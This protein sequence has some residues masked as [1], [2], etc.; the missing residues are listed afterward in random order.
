M[1]ILQIIIIFLIVLMPFIKLNAQSEEIM[2]KWVGK[3][4]HDMILPEMVI[5]F[6]QH[7]K[8]KY[9]KELRRFKRGDHIFEI[10]SR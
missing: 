1:N 9:P 7:F 8:K 5:K 10:D 3:H 2:R 4:P 6:R